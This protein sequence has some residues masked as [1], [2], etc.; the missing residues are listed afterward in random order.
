[1]KKPTLFWAT[2]FTMLAL[3]SGCA[4]SSFNRISP[5]M[6]TPENDSGIYSFSF[7]LKNTPTGL[8]KGTLKAQ[9]VINGETYDMQLEAGSKNTFVYDYQMPPSQ[10]EATYYYILSY[11]YTYSGSTKHIVEYSATGEEDLHRVRLIGRYPIQLISNRGP[12]GAK[13]A[14]VG[15][16]FTSFDKIVIGDREAPTQFESDTSIRF[17]IPPITAGQTYPVKLRTGQG[18]IDAGSLRVDPSMISVLP[19]SINLTKGGREI[20][21]FTVNLDAPE[22]GLLVDVTTDVAASVVMPEVIIPAGSRTVSINLE[23]GEPGTGSL[24]VEAPG[25]APVTVPISV[26]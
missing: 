7:K 26:K 9:L 5:P 15:R 18:D 4:T 14:L 19:Q 8:V 24:F 2:L 6:R 17:T 22:G 16:G 11:D 1:M 25:F 10:K 23:G 20:V 12:V 21:I 3:L 13:I